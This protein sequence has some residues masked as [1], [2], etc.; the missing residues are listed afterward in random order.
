MAI[1]ALVASLVLAPLGI[2]FGHIS[3]SQIKKTGEDGRGLAIAGLVLGYVGTALAAI[4]LIVVLVFMASV[5]SALHHET[6]RARSTPTTSESPVGVP[7]ASART[8]KN[9]KVGDCIRRVT[10][11]RKKDGTNDV[12]VY[13]ASCG[14]K[15]ATDKVI[16]RTT[17]T[18]DC[19]GGQW[20]R[21]QA[22]KPPIVL[23]LS[24][25]R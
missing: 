25:L 6:R 9:A 22:Y 23:C 7:D 1:A 5:G 2:V 14:S 12:T 24:K 8:I 19:T 17:T 20:V 11:A 3:L 21:T 13:T 10:G 4:A 18:S 16:K 15:T